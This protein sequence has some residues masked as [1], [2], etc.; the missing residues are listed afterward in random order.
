M[1][2]YS[3]KQSNQ[4]NHDFFQNVFLKQRFNAKLCNLYVKIKAFL[5]KLLVLIKKFHFSALYWFSFEMKKNFLPDFNFC[6]LW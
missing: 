5:K 2:N 1:L 6:R 3:K 4:Q